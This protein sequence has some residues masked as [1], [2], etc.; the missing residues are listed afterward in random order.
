MPRLTLTLDTET[1]DYFTNLAREKRTD[2]AGIL[3]QGLKLMRVAREQ[4]KV[5]RSHLGFT[6]DPTKL[7]V[8]IIL[9]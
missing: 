4:R 3:E 1:H 8:E 7:D 6:S 2:I 9:L 5:G